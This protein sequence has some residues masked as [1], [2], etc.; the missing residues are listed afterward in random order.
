MEALKKISIVPRH[1]SIK[2]REITPTMSLRRGTILV[3]WK[4]EVD[5][6]YKQDDQPG[7]NGRERRGVD[8]EMGPGGS[9]TDGKL[10]VQSEKNP[11]TPYIEI[12]LTMEKS[13]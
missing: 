11:N 4:A 9:K 7:A 2:Q 1:L 12:D 13:R 8:D 10:Y 3:N 6:M 5:V